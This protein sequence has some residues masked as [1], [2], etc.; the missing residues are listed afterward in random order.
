M[1]FKKRVCHFAWELHDQYRAAQS[2]ALGAATTIICWK[3][4]G[5]VGK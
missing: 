4:L 2:V 5:L 1:S 3:W